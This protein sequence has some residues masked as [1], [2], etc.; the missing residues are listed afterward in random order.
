[1]ER[2]AQEEIESL[3]NKILT[4]GGLAEE[5]IILSNKIF[6]ERNENL[7]CEVLEKEEK[8]NK[9][10]MEIDEGCVRILALYQP[11]ATDLRTIMAATKIN[12][13]LERVADQAVNMAETCSYHFLK[14]VPVTPLTEIPRMSTIAQEMIKQSLDAFTKRDAELAKSVLQK[15]D[16]L[17]TL[18]SNV[19]NQIIGLIKSHPEKA[20]QFIDLILISKNLEKIGDHATNISE[21]VIFMVIGKDIRHH[22][23][24]AL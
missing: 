12:A 18:K 24:T 4:M 22:A 14:E 6:T 15:D 23:E 7:C 3:K 1:M 10:Q 9:L 20:K 2:H 11:E 8:V 19:F 13:E 17:D 16:E 21:D 5:M